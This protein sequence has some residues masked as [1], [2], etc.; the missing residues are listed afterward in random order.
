M[1]RTYFLFPVVFL[2][3]LISSCEKDASKK[4]NEDLFQKFQD[5][6]AEARP[7]VRWWWN[8]NK[9]KK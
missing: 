3:F 5:P 4:T 8:G 6:P 1:V 2:I 9:I 7:F